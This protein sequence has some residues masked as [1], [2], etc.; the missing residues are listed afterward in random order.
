MWLFSLLNR[1]SDE[2]NLVFLFVSKLTFQL[3]KVS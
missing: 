2:I 3:P 1:D